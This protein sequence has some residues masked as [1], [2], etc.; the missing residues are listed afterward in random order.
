MAVRRVLQIEDPADAPIL[1]AKAN[2]I[3]AFDASLRTLVDDMIETMHDAFGVGIAAPQVGVQR[4]V[5]IVEEPAEYEELEDGTK[6]ETRAAQLFVMINPEI[7]KA[8]E[9]VVEL[10]EGCLSMP[11]R[12][13]EVPRHAWVTVK[14]HDL[15]G[16]EQRIRRSPAERYRV[17]HIVQ[18]EIDHLNGIMFTDRMP[19]I[20]K[21][22]DVREAQAN[23]TK[24]RALL[25]R[26]RAAAR[27]KQVEE[28]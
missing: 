4:R 1:R 26:R 6:R 21:L 7:I 19:D 25:M 17:G 16:K 20:S 23:D 8:S 11:G 24:K 10:T 2:R 3:S 5:L 18:H 13:G 22:E 28:A 15:N 12:Y 9:E 14:Y 27:N